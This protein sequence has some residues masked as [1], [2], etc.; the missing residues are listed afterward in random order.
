MSPCLVQSRYKAQSSRHANPVPRLH[1]SAFAVKLSYLSAAIQL[2][3]QLPNPGHVSAALVLGCVDFTGPH[4]HRIYPHG[5]TDTQPYATMGSGSPAAMAIF[6]SKYKEGLTRDE[7]VPL[8]TEAIFFGIFN[9]LGRGSNVDICVI[10]EGNKEFLR[11][12]LQPNP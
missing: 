1:R 10:T 8:V 12:H 6:E 5:S 3:S 11:N 4:L 7:G 9:D 2:R